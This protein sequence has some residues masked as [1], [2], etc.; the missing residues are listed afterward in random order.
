MKQQEKPVHKSSRQQQ[1][2]QE[3]RLHFTVFKNKY[4][5]VCRRHNKRHLN[6]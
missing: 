2:Q 5:A 6:A 4:L 3:V 1:Q